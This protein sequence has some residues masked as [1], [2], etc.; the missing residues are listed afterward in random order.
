VS[1]GRSPDAPGTVRVA[2]VV[3]DF[4]GTTSDEDVSYRL[5]ERF[6]RP[7]WRELDAEFEREAIGSRACLLG[8]AALLDAG[9]A[10]MLS[11]VQGHFGLASSFPA[12]VAWA[13]ERDV[14][15]SVASDGLGFHVEPMLEAGGVARSVRVFTN[16]MT[17]RGGEPV[18]SFPHRHPLCPT[19]GT[20][21]MRVV[22]RHRAD[23]PV[24]FV[25]DGF[26]DRLGALYA[27]VVFAKDHLASYC[28]KRGVPFLPWST[29]DDVRRRLEELR[30]LPGP[31]E[32]EP[33]RCPG[34]SAAVGA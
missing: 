8:Q 11:Y 27:D 28:A 19:C 1:S 2:A 15:V 4:D 13:N 34:W 33:A 5:F 23:G 31:A 29:F 25:G 26:S 17:L 3:V 10:E 14:A 24:A 20:C 30:N 32:T 22:T 9:S 6:G 21:K 16:E 7:G 12:F 18:F